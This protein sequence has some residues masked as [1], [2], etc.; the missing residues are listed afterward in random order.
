LFRGRPTHCPHHDW[1]GRVYS[2]N[3]FLPSLQIA[4]ESQDSCG[5]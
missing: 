2:P 5:S 3:T 4:A 1:K